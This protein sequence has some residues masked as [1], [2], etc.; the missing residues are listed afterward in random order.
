MAP[1]VEAVIPFAEKLYI[2]GPLGFL[3]AASL[4]AAAYLFLVLAKERVRF[5]NA[6][7]EVLKQHQVEMQALLERYIS[8]SETWMA[9]YHEMAESQD[10]TIKALK[11]LVDDMKG[12][13]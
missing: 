12:R 5:D 7:K 9:K 3:A 11:Q 6:I 10:M 8:K 13:R 2:Y 1:G 4:I